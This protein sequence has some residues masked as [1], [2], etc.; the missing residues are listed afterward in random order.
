M[1]S[2]CH[3]NDTLASRRSVYI[4]HKASVGY[5]TN[6]KSPRGSRPE[7]VGQDGQGHLLWD[8]RAK[9]AF[10]RGQNLGHPPCVLS[11]SSQ[12]CLL[13]HAFIQWSCSANEHAKSQLWQGAG[14]QKTVA[15]SL[16]NVCW[17]EHRPTSAPCCPE[18]GLWAAY[19]K[20]GFRDF[21]LPSWNILHHSAAASN[22]GLWR[23]QGHE[24]LVLCVRSI[25]QVSTF[26]VSFEE[27]TH[28]WPCLLLRSSMAHECVYLFIYLPIHIYLSI[29]E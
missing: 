18:D 9:A 15:G 27:K 3:L 14:F 25:Q 11:P 22:V 7:L 26:W 29:D 19:M 28:A 5:D 24:P 12:F 8:V 16:A 1:P 13:M 4:N 10:Q 23:A 20:I 6:Y 21:C 17:S 2:S